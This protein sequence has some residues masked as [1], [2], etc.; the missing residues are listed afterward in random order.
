M[1]NGSRNVQSQT[2]CCI[3]WLQKHAKNKQMNHQKNPKNMPCSRPEKSWKDRG[4]PTDQETHPID[5][6]SYRQVLLL[7]RMQQD[8]SCKR[9]PETWISACTDICSVICSCIC[10]H[11]CSKSG[12]PLGRSGSPPSQAALNHTSDLGS[13]QPP[14]CVPAPGCRPTT[15][16]A[17]A[18]PWPAWPTMAQAGSVTSFQFDMKL[19]G[20]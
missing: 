14:R 5:R 15:L 8:K 4:P 13:A 19:V 12:F 10:V 20:V 2:N 9:V 3:R 16:G 11:F 17:W 7:S 18:W 1:L 6:T